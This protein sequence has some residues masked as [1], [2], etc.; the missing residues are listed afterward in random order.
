MEQVTFETL[1]TTVNRFKEHTSGLINDLLDRRMKVG[2]HFFAVTHKPAE[3]FSIQ[4]L[5]SL[6]WMLEPAIFVQFLPENASPSPTPE[7]A[8]GSG[9]A[10]SADPSE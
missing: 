6:R 4:T 9:H 3:E 1:E 2:P 5:R 8:N 7:A 10:G